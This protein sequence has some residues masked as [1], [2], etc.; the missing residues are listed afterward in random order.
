MCTHTY[1]YNSS[2]QQ[3]DAAGST[4]LADFLM[5]DVAQ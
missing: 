2:W 3:P 4:R 5:Y 1:I